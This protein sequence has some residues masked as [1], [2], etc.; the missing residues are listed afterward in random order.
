LPSACSS[1]LCR[2]AALDAGHGVGFQDD[3]V[4]VFQGGPRACLGSC[5]RWSGHEVTA[6][7]RPSSEAGP[8]TRPSTSG[9]FAATS[10]SWLRTAGRWSPTRPRRPADR[11]PRPYGLER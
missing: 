9:A 4:V 11:R 1:W 3:A 2:V 10:S 7:S 5:P 6:G 8:V